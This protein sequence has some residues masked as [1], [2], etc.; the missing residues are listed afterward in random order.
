MGLLV[1]QERIT[2]QRNTLTEYLTAHTWIKSMLRYLNE[3]EK[4]L[5][6]GI[7]ESLD[8]RSIE[9]QLPLPQEALYP[10]IPGSLARQRWFWAITRV[11][12]HVRTSL[13]PGFENPLQRKHLRHTAVPFSP[14][15]SAVLDYSRP[16]VLNNF[17]VYI[18]VSAKS[19]A[20]LRRLSKE[21]GASM[22]AGIYALAGLVMMEFEEQRHP[23]VP[24]KERKAFITGFPLNPRAFFNHHSDPDS[25]MLAFSDG[26]SLPFLPSSLDLDGRIR[27]LARQAQRQL[28]TYQKRAR[29]TGETAKVQNLNSRGAGLVLANQYLFSLDRLDSVLPEDRRTGSSV[30]GEY[31]AQK[32]PTMQTCGVSSIGS[33]DAFLKAGTYDLDD[34][35]KDLVVDFRDMPSC[36]RTREGEFLFGIAGSGND[37]LST[38]SVDANMMD[39]ELVEGWK[40]RFETILEDDNDNTTSKL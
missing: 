28:A 20:R 33:R 31:P 26:I 40:R 4:V 3:S 35:S 38:P 6:E 23:H 39:P 7:T 1:S 14:V 27:L 22:G 9:R 11:L 8:L 30:Q 21:V 36:V 24:L 16:P 15:Y 19:T 32:N 37:L 34:T 29:P 17:P 12:R 13:P 18:R 10:K 2:N 5:R 25:M